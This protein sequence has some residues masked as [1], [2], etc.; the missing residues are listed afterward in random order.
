M[1]SASDSHYGDAGFESRPLHIVFYCIFFPHF[2]V[3][4]GY[5]R[6]PKRVYRGLNAF[7]IFKV[8][9]FNYIL[10]K[11]RHVTP[12]THSSTLCASSQNQHCLKITFF[13]TQSVTEHVQTHSKMKIYFPMIILYEIIFL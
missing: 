4:W 2:S 1:V 12:Q 10:A 5:F 7:S 11:K 8:N 13:C 6:P 9:F 3:F